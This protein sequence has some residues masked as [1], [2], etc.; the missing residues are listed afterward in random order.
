VGNSPFGLKGVAPDANL[1]MID[2]FSLSNQY[3]STIGDYQRIAFTDD[4]IRALNLISSLTP[5]FPE[6]TVNLSLSGSTQFYAS[7]CDYTSIQLSN[8]IQQLKSLRVA[9]IVSTGNDGR[10]TA[11]GSPACM[12]NTIKVAASDKF[13]G[14]FASFS[15]AAPPNTFTGPMFVAPGTS[16]QTSIPGGGYA[17]YD[18]TSLAAPHVAG[19][20]AVVKAAFPNIS[21]D[22]INAYFL[23][24]ASVPVSVPVTPPVSPYSLQRVVVPTY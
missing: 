9:T 18:G 7:N 23:T 6:I 4:I 3:D 10:R 24:E 14:A 21:V 12:S 5:T 1:F 8:A 13:T 20:Y 16:I 11:I 2:I 19:L 22:S 17:Y 15:N